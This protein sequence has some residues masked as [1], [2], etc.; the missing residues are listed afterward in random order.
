MDRRFMYAEL[1]AGGTTVSVGRSV[2]R[3]R[4]TLAGLL[5]WAA[6]TAVASLAAWDDP[7]RSVAA[8][9]ALVGL[10]LWVVGPLRTSLARRRAGHGGHLASV[11]VTGTL[12]IG[13]VAGLLLAGGAIALWVAR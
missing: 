10:L 5:L 3:D 1:G 7:I 8:G 13:T 6:G 9:G 2:T 11:A 12:A 4:L